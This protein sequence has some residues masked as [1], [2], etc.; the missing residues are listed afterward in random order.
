[1]KEHEPEQ[2]CR[3]GR[4]NF[5]KMSML[6]GAAGAATG[7]R[8]LALSLPAA[9]AELIPPADRIKRDRPRLLL[10]PTE[11]RCAVSLQQLKTLPR[12]ADFQQMLERLEGLKPPKAA[13]LALV[14]LLTGRAE[15]A[16]RTLEVF[17]SWQMP[18]DPKTINDPFFVYF[19][20]SDMAL[21]YDWLHGYAGFD[22]RAK[23][24]LR[25]K[26]Q[27]LADSALKLG[28]D[29]VFHN[30][31]WMFNC[32]AM[33]WALAAAGEDPAADRLYAGLRQRFNGQLFPAMKYLEGSN[34]DAA[35]YWWRYCQHYSLM[36]LL[37]AQSA[38][39][40]DVVATIRR[41]QGDWLGRQLEYL[42]FSVLPDMRFIPWGDIVAGANGGVT[43]EM[44]G[45]IDALTWALQSPH[46]AY[47]SHW[48]AEKRGPER[49]YGETATYYFLYTRNL[50]VKPAV[51]PLA[52]LAGGR[53]GG[54]AIMRSDWSD[55]ATV[56][57]F[58]ATDYFGQHLHLDQ[59]SFVIFRNG[60][61]ALDAGTYQRVGGEQQRTDAHNTLLLGGQGQRPEHYQSARTL[62]AFT[63]RLEQG[64]ET[65]DIVFYKDAGPWTAVAG[66]FAQ[67]YSPQIIQSCV[68]Q[69]LFVRPG[70]VVIVDHLAAPAGKTLPEVR[71]LLQVPGV[72][73][74]NER[75][76]TAL[77]GKSY[78]RCRPLSPGDSRPQVEKSYRTP[79]GANSS[80][81]VPAVIDT[82]RVVYVYE[83][84]SRLALVH[85]LEVGDG[86]PPEAGPNLKLDL[87][88]KAV[89]LLLEGKTFRFSAG[90][91]FE[92][93][94]EEQL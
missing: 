7:T 51:P 46:G 77:N 75:A 61:L 40:T 4:R 21:A 5:L 89:R 12:D 57:G 91:A 38:S 50:T 80:S 58:R 59:G 56:V 92:V 16:Q 81:G 13:A 78:L 15:V 67:A 45:R 68:R 63:E 83:G 30:Y 72:P 17:R 54:H 26:L 94:C 52:M 31:T 41:R 23:T 32:G 87:D 49:F 43:H 25:Q 8:S 39:E 85:L 47:L 76:V 18:D 1:M 82:S 53:Q 37:A 22:D 19:T 35:G 60:M 9:S 3:R 88:G 71:W 6:L 79:A 44:A 20:L 29:H 70:T 2:A 90:P 34:A 84:T 64:L 55:G 27:P 74:V 69:L 42:V 86:E 14:Y 62:A 11:T 48:L 65:G 93:S 10:R 28:N 24:A 33:L 36:V 73:T 66:Q